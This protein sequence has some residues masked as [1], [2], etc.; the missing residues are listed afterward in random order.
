MARLR[1][2]GLSASLGASLTNS[3]TS[4]TFAAALTHSGGTNVPT[5]SGSDYI[6]LAILNSSGHLS[7]IVWLTAY[8]SGA[9]TGT[10]SRG[11]EGTSGVSHSSGDKV[12][13]SMTVAD[14]D[15]SVDSPGD[16]GWASALSYDVEFDTDGSSLPAG[17]SWVNQGSATW[18]QAFGAGVLTH[19]GNASDD[20]K[21][22]VRALPTESTWTAT[23]KIGI[24][25]PDTTGYVVG[26]CLRDSASGKLFVLGTRHTRTFAG[27]HFASPTSFTSTQFTTINIGDMFRYV[28]IR[29][30]SATSWDLQ[31]SPDGVAWLRAASAVNVTT[32][33][34]TPD[35][36]GLVVYRIGATETVGSFH[37]FR[38][39]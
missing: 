25:T 37:W 28:R 3:A 19:P 35:Q 14:F 2:N 27:F 32:T 1:Y 36:I 34:G 22:I 16:S 24:G 6:P 33:L 18:A 20:V 23:A 31:G 15:R 17:W 38:V 21:A 5:I 9:T 26:M 7:E 11:Q 39:R 10:I 13:L 8:T 12:V 4:V 30:N 29:R